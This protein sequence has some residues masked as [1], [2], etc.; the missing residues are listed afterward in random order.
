M[1]LLLFFAVYFSV[2]DLSAQ[3]IQ[4]TVFSNTGDLIPYASISIKGTSKGTSANNEGKFSLRVDSGTITLV[5]QSVG[6]SPEEKEISLK[7]DTDISFI[8]Y[9]QKLTMKEV[10]VRSNAEDPAYAI[11]RE[12]IKKREYYNTEVKRFTCDLY[13]KDIIR[14]IKLPPKVMG[15]TIKDDDK[16]EMNLDSSGKGIVYLSESI[17]FITKKVPDKLKVDV[18]SSRVSGSNGVGV[19]FPVFISLYNSNVLIFTKRFNPRGFVSPIAD[20][21]IHFY[22]FK[23]LGTFWENGKP[24]HSIKVIP[25]RLYEPLFTG[26]INITDIDWRIHS[27]DLFISKSAQ[28]ELLDS[29]NIKQLHVAINDTAWQLNTQQLSFKAS[30][31]GVDLG[32]NFN[33]VFTN[34]NITPVINNKSFGRVFMQYDTAA[35][36][37]GAVYW[38][39]VRPV[40]LEVDELRDYRFKDSSFLAQRDSVKLKQLATKEKHKPWDIF[41]KGLHFSS[42]RRNY[43]LN[44]GM[45]SLVKNLEYNT[46]EG[47]VIRSNFYYDIHFSKGKK[48]EIEP[49]I[50]YGTSNRHVTAFAQIQLFNKK[51]KSSQ[52]QNVFTIS[53]GKRVSAYN[54][55]NDYFELLRNSISTLG[56]GNNYLKTYEN[57]FLQL[58]FLTKYES[59]INFSIS[60]LYE[61]RLPLQNTSDFTFFKKHKALLTDNIPYPL[62]NT[63]P[64]PNKSISITAGIEWQPGQ[65]YIQFPNARVSLGSKS[66]VF[67]I[68]YTKGINKIF[69]SDVDYDKWNMAVSGSTNMK[70]KGVLKFKTEIGGFLNNRSVPIQDFKHFNGNPTRTAI[71]YVNGFQL[72][73]YYDNSTIAPLYGVCHLEQHLNGLLTNKIPFF[74][75]LNWNLV[76]GT[77]AFYVNRLNNYAELFIGLENI[78]KIFRVDFVSGFQNGLR[79]RQAILIGAGGALTGE[80]AAT[81]IRKRGN[82]TQITF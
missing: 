1:R 45:E 29:I 3:R 47:W 55:I 62:T 68:I 58:G 56:N 16:K 23:Y 77:N 12:S 75:K 10:V 37:R 31:L 51:G 17:S 72:A 79:G 38:D 6:Y 4:G 27:F 34:Y 30:L 82:N 11:I 8:L 5:C 28:L 76:G 74:R 69:G 22:K 73:G 65:R 59:G 63:L 35:A 43:F 60:G 78:F 48:I 32:G 49:T 61:D 33:S 39:S 44:F 13:A 64:L 70:L 14:L 25:R 53:G 20:N 46:A 40:P 36:K 9:R 54:G 80:R 15:R 26:V 71:Q 41:L 52:N 21:A 81:N 57:T 67:S 19:S 18:R 7:G 50:R 42:F 66:P 2:F 24:I